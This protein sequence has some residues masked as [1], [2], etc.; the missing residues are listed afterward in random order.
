M[1][2][3]TSSTDSTDSSSDTI[4]D[5]RNE[6]NDLSP[7]SSIQQNNSLNRNNRLNMVISYSKEFLCILA[8]I[9]TTFASVQNNSQKLSR[10][11][12][13]V[14]FFTKGSVEDYYTGQLNPTQTKVSLSD[15]S[16]VFYYAPW[17]SESQV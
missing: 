5:R 10:A 3:A 9:L 12:A 7:D 4:I 16:F 15:L 14:P 2:F 8:F 1:L 17:C 13:P 11:E 6:V